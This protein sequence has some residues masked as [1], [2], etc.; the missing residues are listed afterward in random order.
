M[1]GAEAGLEI[2]CSSSVGGRQCASSIDLFHPHR[3]VLHQSK[4]V[5]QISPFISIKNNDAHAIG[6]I[7]YTAMHP[8]GHFSG[9]LECH[10]ARR[11][12]S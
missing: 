4:D 12:G 10:C 6:A 11:P 9:R 7:T 2:V 5:G 3:Q 8:L 1:W